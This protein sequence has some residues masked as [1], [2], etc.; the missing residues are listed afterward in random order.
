VLSPN[1]SHCMFQVN[2]LARHLLHLAY[3]TN[4]RA[5]YRT[6]KICSEIG[7]FF[8][9]RETN[10]YHNRSQPKTVKWNTRGMQMY[11]LSIEIVTLMNCSALTSSRVYH[12]QATIRPNH[13]QTRTSCSV[14][15]TYN[16]QTE[17]RSLDRPVGLKV[18]THV[19]I[20]MPRQMLVW[21]VLSVLAPT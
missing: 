3:N 17:A 9:A 8:G 19:W 15:V 2:N 4:I 11:G 20:C 12:T 10:K 6:D 14:R 18:A 5:V 7:A 16:K 13:Y 1:N 21:C